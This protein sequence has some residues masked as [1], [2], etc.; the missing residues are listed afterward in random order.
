MSPKERERRQRIEVAIRNDLTTRLGDRRP[1]K[2]RATKATTKATTKA[3][4]SRRR[5]IDEVDYSSPSNKE[6]EEGEHT[7]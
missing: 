3:S 6:E 1:L 5:S 7:S 4:N 2:R